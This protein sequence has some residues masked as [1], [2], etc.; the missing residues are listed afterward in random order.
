[1]KAN[2]QTQLNKLLNSITALHNAS[3]DYKAELTKFKPIY[4]KASPTEQV[5]IRNAVAQLVGKLYGTKPITLKTGALG[6]E[7][8]SAES[9]ALR[10]ILPVDRLSTKTGKP[11][12]RKSV[13]PVQALLTK[14]KAMNKTEQRRF[15]TAI[16]N[17]IRGDAYERRRLIAS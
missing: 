1:M 6:F 7:R 5:E 4:D 12:V 13:D 16:A 2:T 15:L 9:K 14:F 3:K 8:S 17:V 10:R 11:V